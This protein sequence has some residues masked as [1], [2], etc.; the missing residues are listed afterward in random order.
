MSLPH[1]QLC[2][3]K[4]T[5]FNL[6]FK[7]VMISRSYKGAGGWDRLDGAY[8]MAVVSLVGGT[9]VVFGI[10]TVSLLWHGVS[11]GIASARSFCLTVQYP[12]YTI[13]SLDGRLGWVDGFLHG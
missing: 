12:G 4:A 9:Q 10:Y 8:L 11:C 1:F 6:V 13:S 5:A 3:V 2:H 7:Q